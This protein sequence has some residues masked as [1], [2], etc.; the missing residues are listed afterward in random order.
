LKNFEIIAKTIFG[1]EEI[2]AQEL[3]EL[4]AID[5]V[6]LTRAVKY[7]GDKS[8]LYKSNLQLRTAIKVL[9][10]IASFEVVNE[11]QLYQKVK[12]INWD[13]YMSAEKTFAIDGIVSSDKFTH[14]KFVALKSK[15]AIAD[16][17]REKYGVRPSVDIE[18]PDL[19]I[20]IHIADTTCSVS[21]DS[22]G[23]SLGKRGYKLSQTA[24]PLS[25]VLA[26][27][28]IILSGWDKEREFIDAMSGS[29]TFPIEAALMA[30][31]IPPG[32]FRSFNFEKWN[33]FD[34]ELWGA[35][36][37]DAENNIKPVHI[38]IKAFDIDIKAVQIGKENATRAGVEKFISFEKKDF[39]K[40]APESDNAF[41]VMNP[42]YGERLEEKDQMIPFY[43]EIGDHLKQAYNGCDSWIFSGNPEAMKF[44]GL[45]PSKKIKLYNGPIECRLNKYELYRGS[46]KASKQETGSKSIPAVDRFSRR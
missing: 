46:R 4:G 12:S 13:E 15:D 31:N 44:I 34:A 40:S 18:D 43:K 9:K 38:K 16:Q 24:A 5:I 29:G 3:K 36:K 22:S 35:I 32:S 6:Q 2:L 39:L 41:V 1:F 30:G 14:S 20:N 45:R 25:E 33:D 8:L 7:K 37:K 28:I 23:K 27:G 19:R 17:F 10:P 42:P 21:L 26:A 11:E